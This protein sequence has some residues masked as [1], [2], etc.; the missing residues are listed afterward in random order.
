MQASKP[1]LLTFS[2]FL[3]KIWKIPQ[4][5]LEFWLFEY[6]VN[7]IQCCQIVVCSV[8]EFI[9]WLS[10]LQNS[11]SEGEGLPHKY[12]THKVLPHSQTI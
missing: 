1:S 12:S 5:S 10:E 7:F 11:N 4:N 2:L 9:Q 3:D 8:A 6:K